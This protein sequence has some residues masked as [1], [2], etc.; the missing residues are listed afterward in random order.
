MPKCRKDKVRTSS[1]H[2]D[3]FANIRILEAIADDHRKVV[4]PDYK[5]AFR[6]GQDVIDRLLPYH[7]FQYPEA[8]LRNDPIPIEKETKT[9]VQ[10]HE[11]FRILQRRY[12]DVARQ[13]ATHSTPLYI[14]N[15]ATRYVMDHHR[16]ENTDLHLLHKNLQAQVTSERAREHAERLAREAKAAQ[17]SQV[18][19]L[20]A[21]LIHAQ[22]EGK[23]PAGWDAILAASSGGQP[24][25]RTKG[26]PLDA[27]SP[28]VT[29]WLTSIV[30]QGGLNGAAALTNATPRPMQLVTPTR[31]SP[32]DPN[33]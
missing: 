22:Q 10:F 18:Q 16:A 27:A 30:V 15:M 12:R 33:R 5:T 20:Q 25:P 11:R 23:L 1:C 2:L 13:D 8:D 29:K 21:Q 6:D 4:D 32:K 17:L 19:K 24:S 3:R 28:E 31:Q 7:V 14:E 26:Q 9:A